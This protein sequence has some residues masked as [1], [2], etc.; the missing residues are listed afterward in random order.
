MAVVAALVSI[1]FLMFAFDKEP[2]YGGQ[3]LGHWVAEYGALQRKPPYKRKRPESADAAIKA[4][5]TNALPF[6]VRWIGFEPAPWRFQLGAVAA[7][8]PVWITGE[9]PLARLTVDSPL[10][11]RAE[12][13]TAAFEVL[14]YLAEPAIPEL[15][16][17]ARNSNAP[18]ASQRALFALSCIGPA[19]VPAITNVINLPQFAG[20]ICAV[21]CACNMRTNGTALMPFV[22]SWLTSSDNALVENTLNSLGVMAPDVGFD[23]APLMP[24]LVKCLDNSRVRVRR[25][26][27]L[28]LQTLG[29]RA[30]AALPA[31]T[32]ALSDPDPA[33]RS[34]AE[35]V[36]ANIT[37]IRRE[38]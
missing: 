28:P 6:L 13:T 30:A 16:R 17:I 19:A 3:P 23:P 4:C 14:G 10:E 21:T 31:V 9:N 32:N 36:I 2:T 7:R 37:G 24:A 25:L 18:A 38:E 15:E 33:V 22:A 27:L 1:G 26:A 29:P 35:L 12:G 34:C 11:D 5:G 8:L 20:T